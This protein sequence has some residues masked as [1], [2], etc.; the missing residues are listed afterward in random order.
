M[1]I[2]FILSQFPVISE[3]FILNQIT[4]LL[5]RGHAVDIFAGRSREYSKIHTDIKK[6]NLLKRTYYINIPVNKFFRIIKGVGLLI[7]NFHKKPTIILKSLNVIKLGRKAATLN[8]L[9]SV[10]PFLDKGPYDIVHCHFGPN[11]NLGVLLKDIGAIQ[12][13]IIAT[14]HGYD[15]TSHPKI[16]GKRVYKDLFQKVDLVTVN[17]DFI[18]S[19][20]K[21][22]GCNEGKIIKLPVGLNTIEFFFKEKNIK[23]GHIIKIL[24]VARLVEKKGVEY[25]IKAV[26]KVIKNY[27][28]I[29][30]YIVGDGPLRDR[31]Q[32]LI[33]QLGVINM[34]KLLGWKNQDE[35]RQLYSE[36]HIF[37]LS[38]VTASN[39]DQEG[40]GLVL[41]EAQAMGLPVISTLHNGI[42]DSVLD[43]KSGFLVPEKDVNALA[44]R[45]EFL[46]ENPE[47]WSEMGRAGREYVEENFDINK[48]NDRLVKIYQQLL[49][50]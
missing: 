20:V 2:A 30:Y 33:E 48:L 19:K 13:K 8:M 43:G 39:G 15:A 7:T 1:K 32:E 36:A 26:A 44:E 11:G 18:K 37:I 3:T 10:I 21:Q 17:S 49:K 31:L 5:D 40:Q 42:P 45:L 46:I 24:T 25:S 16:Y 50:Q 22:L 28:N 35:I 12:G 27:P 9:Y 34:V 38:S 47:M 29:K 6:Y 4:G 41:Q 23:P 14:F